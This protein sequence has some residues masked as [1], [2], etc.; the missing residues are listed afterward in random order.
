MGESK[1]TLKVRLAE[2]RRAVQKSDVNNG[3]A[4]HVANTSH[5]IDWANARVVK[6]VPGYWKRRTTEAILIKNSQE[7][8]NLDSGLLLPS[9]WN[10]ILLN[11]PLL[12]HPPS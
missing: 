8:M 6:T 9:V 7:P 5:N 2:H 10:F 11:T 4:M 12:P 3:T 1:R